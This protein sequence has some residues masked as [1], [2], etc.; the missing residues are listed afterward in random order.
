MN[1]HINFDRRNT[2]KKLGLVTTVIP[3]ASFLG[4]QGSESTTT[5]TAAASSSS[6]SSS[7]SVAGTTTS[8][9]CSTTLTSTRDWA[10]GG[11]ELI[12]VDFPSNDIF[13]NSGTCTVSTTEN[14]T[15]GPCYLGVEDNID[16]SDN[17]TGLPMQ[18]CIQLIDTNDEP[19]EGY[20][21]E[22]WHCDNEGIYSGDESQSD[23]TSTFRVGFC[24]E[25]DSAALASTWFRGEQIS[26][27]SGRVN[28]QSCF[29][30]WYPSRTV[31]IHFRVRLEEGGNDYVVSQFCFDD[32][33]TTDILTTH[34]KYSSI[35]LSKSG[36]SY[37]TL[38]SGSDTVFGSN[39][40]D[41]LL[42]IEQNSDGTLL[43]F[44]KIK[45]DV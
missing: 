13:E 1:K 42:H 29:P 38:A 39:Y 36:S 16:I 24:T 30:G 35:G 45:I 2:L 10:S 8:T 20:L 23:D 34:D 22:V 5:S 19:L 6:A 27:S 14:M 44:H 37:T 7:S 31:H 33:F 15:E 25:N 28:F 21:I 41:G 9:S 26:N 12:T 40:E 18:L 32:D 3:L 43:A 11:T 17:K 4:C